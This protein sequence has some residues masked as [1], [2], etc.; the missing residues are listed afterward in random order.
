MN[1]ASTVYY[2]VVSGA[3]PPTPT[4]DQVKAQYDTY[5]GQAVKT[6]GTTSASA[7]AEVAI[8]LSGYSDNEVLSVFVVAEDAA[9]NLQSVPT[10]L[11]LIM[12]DDS[13]PQFVTGYPAA[14]EIRDHSFELLVTLNEAGQMTKLSVAAIKGGKGFSGPVGFYLQMGGDPSKLPKA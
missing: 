1:E 8:N 4:S 5:Q 2:Y 3:T 9:G 14:D 11:D 7:N 6:K 13:P 10:K 12:G